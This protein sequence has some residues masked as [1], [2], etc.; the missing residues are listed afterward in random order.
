MHLRRK[1]MSAFSRERRFGWGLFIMANLSLYRTCWL[2]FLVCSI[3][4]FSV[5]AGE[6]E[7][8]PRLFLIGDS[9]VQ[10]KTR[11]FQGWG[12][13]FAKWVDPKQFV[14]ENRASGGRSSRSYL[15]E[16][17][18]D[19]VMDQIQPGDFVLMQF[20]HNDSE[21]VESGL[22]SLPGSGEG[23]REVTF[24]GAPETLRSYGGYLGRYVADT[25]AKGATPIICS[26]V[27]LNHWKDKR[28]LRERNEYA[29]WAAEAARTNGVLFIDLGD[30]VARR[31]EAM[32]KDSVQSMC[33]NDWDDIHTTPVG[34]T[35]IAE[36]VA[37]AIWKLD[38]D[39][40]SKA[41]RGTPRK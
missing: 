39:P 5:R 36:C 37:K 20:G 4:S 11:G 38:I 34:A 16:H 22:G 21:S 13:P 12:T 18:W 19:A 8:V 40:L 3:V 28:L 29:K 23:T 31:Y 35:V 27:P 33:F 41:M 25:K 15:R 30:I 26:P 1:L 9:T 17:Q 32:G 10:N 2:V 14:V 6:H 7:R 24:K